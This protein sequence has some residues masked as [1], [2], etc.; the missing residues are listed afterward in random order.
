MAYNRRVCLGLWEEHIW[1]VSSNLGLLRLRASPQVTEIHG[2]EES[3]LEHVP[4]PVKTNFEGERACLANHFGSSGPWTIGSGVLLLALRQHI[5]V[6]T[7]CGMKLIIS[8]TQETGKRT[9][10]LPGHALVT[11]VAPLRSYFLR[12][13]PL[14]RSSTLGG[15]L[16]LHVLFEEHLK[17]KLEPTLNYLLTVTVMLTMGVELCFCL[18]EK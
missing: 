16:W 4:R 12:P 15:K 14:P 17:P 3:A 13:A 10:V 9:Q 5:K 7:Y 18:V 1:Y 6:G 2:E 11:Y 8:W